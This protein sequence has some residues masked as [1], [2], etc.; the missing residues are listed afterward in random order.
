MKKKIMALLLGVSM[1]A[2]L[3]QGCAGSDNAAPAV[4]QAPAA[5]EEEEVKEAA[6]A[7]EKAEEPKEEKKEEAEVKEEPEE[8]EEVKEEAKSAL[9]LNTK[10]TFDNRL[11]KEGKVIVMGHYPEI[12]VE[13]E[14]YDALSDA[15]SGLTKE[16]ADDVS[17]NMDEYKEYAENDIV[18]RGELPGGYYTYEC[19]C[20]VTKADEEVVSIIYTY[21]AFSGGA[22][23]STWY[24]S[25]NFS[26][27][28]G[29]ELNAANVVSDMDSL[30]KL[31]EDRIEKE[32]ETEDLYFEDDLEVAI[33]DHYETVGDYTFTLDHAGI[34]FY[35]S[36]YDLAAYAA[37]AQIVTINYEDEPGIVKEE[38]AKES[39]E[40]IEGVMMGSKYKLADGNVIQLTWYPGFEDEY[41]YELTATINGKDTVEKIE[42]S[43][44]DPYIIRT[45][46]K[47]Y[48]YVQQLQMN[49]YR[50]IDV[51]SLDGGKLEK[52]GTVDRGFRSVSPTDPADFDLEGRTDLLSTNAMYRS[53]HVGDD[54]MP[55]ANEEYDT[56]LP[57]TSEKL[58]LKQEI[59]AEVFVTED[60][61]ESAEVKIPKGAVLTFFRTDNKTFMDMKDEDDRVIRL[62]PKTGDWPQTIDGKDIEEIFD[63]VIFA[64]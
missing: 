6:P 32:Y 17:K 46:D 58:T 35:F 25:H 10:K 33:K 31:L 26:T 18:E 8:K 5:E 22:H 4:T 21:Y 13:S 29:E 60:S 54:G 52:I 47:Y 36:A 57:L 62:Y 24:V 61:K 14:G 51:Y 9:K 3:L 53:Y 45:G 39:S 23:P 42:C 2:G 15:L 44:M 16:I 48:L 59:T 55:V 40:Y 34:T 1:A 20:L 49:D 63:G 38:Y 19:D 7:E 11:D 28:T 30:P 27:K 37:G 64:G 41:E 12:T 56:V 43:G 50:I